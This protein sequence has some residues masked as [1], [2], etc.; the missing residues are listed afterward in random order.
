MAVAAKIIE[1]SE[2]TEFERY[3]ALP[4]ERRGLGVVYR[5][6]KWPWSIDH[7]LGPVMSLYK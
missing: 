2:A 3:R 6:D 1:M 7:G 4:P 5:K